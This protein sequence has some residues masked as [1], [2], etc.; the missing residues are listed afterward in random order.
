MKGEKVKHGQAR[1]KKL[2][3]EYR[4]WQGMLQRCNNPNCTSYKHYGGRGIEVCEHWYDF[5]IFFKDVGVRPDGLI[6]DRIDNDKDYGPDNWQWATRK[7]QRAN[8]RNR[9][10]QYWFYG[11]GPNGEVVTG[12]DQSYIAKTL[13][14]ERSNVCAC[15][16]GRLKTTGGWEFEKI[17]HE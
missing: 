13:G 2:T 14:L 10:D 9:K 1:R 6:L 5:R 4:I 12:N 16:N 3:P 17:Y 8:Q 15:L 7:E 11:Y